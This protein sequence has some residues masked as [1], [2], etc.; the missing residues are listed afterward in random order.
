MTP[1]ARV[2]AAIDILDDILSGT[3]PEPAL[4]RWGRANRYAGSGDRAAI[5]DHVFDALRR[6]RSFS[7]L[8]G[9]ETGRGLM[10]GAVR[11][12]GGATDEVFSGTGYAPPP[13]TQSE[14]NHD[15]GTL[16]DAAALDIPDW[17]ETPLRDALGDTF[18]P[19]LKRLQSRAPV[20]LRVNTT[21]ATR[22]A[23]QAALNENEIATKPHPM[24]ETALE[25]TKNARRI[26]SS[27]AYRTG[28]VELQ[29]V[30][31]QALVAELAPIS[32][33]ARVLDY[34]AGGGGKAL[35]MAALAPSTQIFAHDGIP[36]RMADLPTRAARAGT[37]ISVVDG[38]SLSAAEPFDLVLC[39]VPCSGS[40]A[41]R[42][43]PA[44]KWDLTPEA[45]LALTVV[46][47]EIL[48]KA[49]RLV[50]PK[51]R[52]AY[53]T[54]SLLK[55]ENVDQIDQFLVQNPEWRLQS[56]RSYSPLEGGD[57]FYMALLKRD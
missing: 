2:A 19:V 26:A 25:V 35:A 13:L 24:V 32:D 18:A 37:P 47:S 48:S 7:S 9:S 11:F 46:Q 10:I 8:G 20:F 3:A 51:G 54:C 52:L 21:K 16:T 56:S 53:A 22:D 41:W 50:A 36:D 14:Q 28:L 39:D 38:K 30:A 12:A 23:A 42:R 31:S 15:P 6:R 43:R 33:T 5:R 17:L 40:G 49:A 29:D 1:P 55:D 27:T 34:C 4:S 45:L 57:G 44:A